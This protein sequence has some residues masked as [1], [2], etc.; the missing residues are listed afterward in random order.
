MVHSS[1]RVRGRPRR[2][3]LACLPQRF[4]L[5]LA[6]SLHLPA[7]RHRAASLRWRFFVLVVPVHN[8]PPGLLEACHELAVTR[9]IERQPQ[10]LPATGTGH[11]PAPAG[12]RAVGSR[13]QARLLSFLMVFGPGLIVMVADN[14]AGAVSTYT[15]AG[16]QYGTQLLWVMAAAA[17]RHLFLPGN[18]GPPGDRDRPRPRRD[19]LPALRQVVGP[20]LAWS[21]SQLVNFLTLVTEFAAITLAFSKVGIPGY[22]CGAHRRARADRPG[23]DGQLPALGTDHRVP[24]LS[25]PG[26]DRSL[27]LIVRPN[28]GRGR[29]GYAHPGCPRRRNYVEPGFS[30]HRHCR[31][32]RRA[33]AALFPAKLHRRQAAALQRPQRERLDTCLAGCLTITAGRR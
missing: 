28:L 14:D 16:A 24:V 33:L 20:F 2:C 8:A 6:F 9:W 23:D 22:Y 4:C 30:D 31:D 5:R 17:A 10:Q 12:T 21:I 3:C 18:G 1:S 25:G 29:T 32:D 11:S 15:Q 19:D 27:A 26:L 13:W 7:P